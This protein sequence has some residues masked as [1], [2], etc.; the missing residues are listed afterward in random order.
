MCTL[1]CQSG[2]FERGFEQAGSLLV[3]ISYPVNNMWPF[4]HY[5][6]YCLSGLLGDAKVKLATPSRYHV[7]ELLVMLNAA[8]REGAANYLE[9]DG[10]LRRMKN[11]GQKNF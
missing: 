3:R 4:Q 9:A 8:K 1:L 5:K 2:K 6:L 10:E 7:P 11:V